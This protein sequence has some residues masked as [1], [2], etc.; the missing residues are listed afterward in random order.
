MDNDIL[1]HLLVSLKD[2]SLDNEKTL[3][4]V[5]HTINEYTLQYFK[6]H[7]NEYE[8]LDAE[9]MRM[10]FDIKKYH[11]KDI[12]EEARFQL[13]Y[14]MKFGKILILRLGSSMVDFNNIFCDECCNDLVTHEK[15]PPYQQFSYLPRAFMLNS[16]QHLKQE[17][18]VNCLYRRKDKVEFLNCYEPIKCHDNFKIIIT[19]CL[20][21]NKLEEYIH[22][23]YLSGDKTYFNI[24]SIPKLS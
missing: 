1:H 24:V 15:Y 12:L 22:N 5:D 10:K 8:I 3:L 14:A 17:L 4:I 9:R 23:N 11:L 19:I 18:L 20:N 13:V 6:Y 7:S 21:H 2:Q 16:G